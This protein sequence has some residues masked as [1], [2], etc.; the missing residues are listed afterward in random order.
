MYLSSNSLFVACPADLQESALAMDGEDG[1][2]VGARLTIEE[3][4]GFALAG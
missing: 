2:A 3:Q 4:G 1:S